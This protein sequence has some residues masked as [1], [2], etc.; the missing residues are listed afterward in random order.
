MKFEKI[1]QG[2]YQDFDEI[3]S[4]VFEP[5]SVFDK[6]K[7]E[8]KDVFQ[9]FGITKMGS[10]IPVPLFESERLEDCESYVRAMFGVK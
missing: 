4:V 6:E 7:K 2:F 9:V 5:S 10:R 3:G 1:T 8:V